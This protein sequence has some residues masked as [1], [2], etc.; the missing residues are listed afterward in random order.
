MRGTWN[1]VLSC[2]LAATMGC[3]LFPEQVSIFEA[4]LEGDGRTLQ[5]FTGGCE[6]QLSVN[7]DEQSADE[8]TVTVTARGADG[9]DCL[10]EATV[11]LSEKLGDRM[12]V[13]GST[14]DIVPVE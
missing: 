14:G 3:G 13:D 11:V 7:V 5:L 8:V 2:A 9:S 1:L 4:A 12:L 10:E 6:G